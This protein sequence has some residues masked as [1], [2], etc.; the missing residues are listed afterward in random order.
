VAPIPPDVASDPDGL[1]D[2]V[3]SGRYRL[4]R[5]IASGGMAT[6]WEGTDQLLARRV[7]IKILH[8]H[9]ARNEAFVR[10]FRGEAVAAARLAH[11]SIV[12]VYDTVEDQGLNAIVMELV[13]GTTVRA[14]LDEHG[15]L[16]LHAVLAIGTQVADALGAAHASGLVHRDVKPANILLSADGRVLVADFG[17]AKAAQGVDLTEAGSMVG[18]AKY[19][20][21]EQVDGSGII[22]GRSDL[23]SLGIVLYEALTGTAPFV[24]ENDVSTA[25]ARLNREPIP[26]RNYRTDI[27]EGVEQVVL[28]A[29][30]RR[31]EDRFADTTAMRRALLSAGADP[32]RA[33]SVARAAVAAA[34]GEHPPARHVGPLPGPATVPIPP[35]IGPQ[36][37]AP[38]HAGGPI[39]PSPPPSFT[40]IPP[41]PPLP[42]PGSTGELLPPLAAPRRRGRVVALLTAAAVIVAL[43]TGAIVWLNG[44]L[45]SDTAPTSLSITSAAAYDPAGDDNGSENNADAPK[46]LDGNP[47]T[48]W[49]SQIYR[50]PD[51]AKGGVGIVLD[52]HDAHHVSSVDLTTAVGG[53]NASIYLLD[54]TTL[55]GGIDGWGD[56]H[57]SIRN[58]PTG[59][60]NV[61][62]DGTTGKAVLIW[63]TRLAPITDRPDRFNVE[64]SAVSVRGT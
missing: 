38:P 9:L 7:A 52:L 57:G 64:V 56:P 62:V 28:R 50:A 44:G 10:R 22:D 61:T 63:F 18:T 53:W 40:R 34:S 4:N 31:P 27:P 5:I 47:D 55:P 49:T 8:P 41:Q 58:A 17:I 45:R 25:L 2:R 43:G 54:S 24:G 16:Q 12:S 32:S 21:P 33:Q 46:V 59:A 35:P 26:P 13:S 11:P 20:S 42:P 19:L 6:V 39:T 3:L 29:M 37:H 51:L 48:A 15:P 36:L 30:A 1:A 23:Y 60:A 14:D